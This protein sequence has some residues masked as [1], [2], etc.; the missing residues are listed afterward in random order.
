MFFQ[1]KA[2]KY[3]EVTT[4]IGEKRPENILWEKWKLAY[5]HV[6]LLLKECKATG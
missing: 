6:V 5:T 4:V 1:V 3:S 2:G